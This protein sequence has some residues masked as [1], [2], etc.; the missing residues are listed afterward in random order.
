MEEP[1]S[2]S[3]F[4]LLLMYF[5]L[6]TITDFVFI[7]FAGLMNWI[8]SMYPRRHVD[9]FESKV[10]FKFD[11][12]SA[13]VEK[14]CVW[15]TLQIRCLEISEYFIDAKVK[16]IDDYNDEKIKYLLFYPQEVELNNG[17]S[18]IPERNYHFARIT[19]KRVWK[20]GDIEVFQSI[21]IKFGVRRFQVMGR[22][23]RLHF[24]PITN[25]WITAASF[26]SRCP[27]CERHYLITGTQCNNCG[28]FADQR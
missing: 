14:L 27:N 19:L 17:T 11:V 24:D 18:W 22:I 25:D 3:N 12:C 28:R 26:F 2:V 13:P 6:F 16:V 20:E 15:E 10:K 7:F 5:Y 23:K 21:K 4:F 1:N 8:E 9:F